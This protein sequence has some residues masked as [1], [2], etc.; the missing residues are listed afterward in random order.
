MHKREREVVHRGVRFRIARKKMKALQ[1]AWRRRAEVGCVSVGAPDTETET[2][3]RSVSFHSFSSGGGGG[4]KA[5]LTTQCV[6]M[7][8]SPNLSKRRANH[9]VALVIRRMGA[10]G[11]PP[12]S[13]VLDP[14]YR[15]GVRDSSG[16]GL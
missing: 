6:Q 5:G 1:P 4:A 14:R 13:M 11:A 10:R 3:K 15:G 7:V 2:G 8:A 12:L 16:T 9:G